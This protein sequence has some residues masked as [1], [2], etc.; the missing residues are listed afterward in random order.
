[1]LRNGELRS[2]A[3][4]R[5]LLDGR[6]LGRCVVRVAGGIVQEYCALTCEL[7]FTEWLSE[8]I[9]LFTEL[10]GIIRLKSPEL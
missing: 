3:S 6:N 8:D 2:I 7:P 9:V 5:V 10:S 1:M 4:N